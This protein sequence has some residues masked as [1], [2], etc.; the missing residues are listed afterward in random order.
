MKEEATSRNS[1]R[2]R[3]RNSIEELKE[4]TKNQKET[5]SHQHVGSS[6]SSKRPKP[7]NFLDMLKERLSG[8]QFRMLNEKLYTC[9]GQEALDYFKEDP[10]MFD[11]VTH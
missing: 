9:S 3:R 6:A 10:T 8:G 4:K 2:K 5:R 11:M 7:S 1:K